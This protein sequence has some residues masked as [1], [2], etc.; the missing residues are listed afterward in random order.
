MQ[1]AAI[2]YTP[3]H[4]CAYKQYANDVARESGAQ[5]TRTSTNAHAHLDIIMHTFMP[6]SKHNCLPPY[7]LVCLCVC[8]INWHNLCS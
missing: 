7:V 2:A 5:D 1:P 3:T 8:I 4:T 6:C